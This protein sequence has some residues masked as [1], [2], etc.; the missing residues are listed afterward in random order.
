[1]FSSIRLSLTPL[2]SWTSC[3]RNTRPSALSRPSCLPT[4]TPTLSGSRPSR[5]TPQ[6]SAL[7]VAGFASIVARSC[8]HQ[9]KGRPFLTSAPTSRPSHS[10]LRRSVSSLHRCDNGHVDDKAQNPHHAGLRRL[11]R[12]DA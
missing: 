2:D 5:S 6:R 4:T 12:L 7:L 10:T 11:Q 9:R 1:M 3:A 8:P